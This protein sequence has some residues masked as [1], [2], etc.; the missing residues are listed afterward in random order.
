MAGTARVRSEH[1]CKMAG[2]EMRA[3]MD[4]MPCCEEKQAEV[5]TAESDPMGVCCVTIPRAPGSS[6]TTF[7]LCHPSFSVALAHTATAQCPVML[8]KRFES[9]YSSEVFLPDLQASYIRNLSLL[10]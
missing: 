3:G 8:P 7:K 6:G 2:T 9:F 1:V 5:A 4:T 10:I